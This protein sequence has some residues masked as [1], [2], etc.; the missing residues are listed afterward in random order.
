M[1]YR[2]QLYDQSPVDDEIETLAKYPLA[3]VDDVDDLLLF[4]RDSAK[5]QLD[6]GGAPVGAFE[7]TRPEVPVYLDQ[8]TDDPVDQVLEF[9]IQW[10]LGAC[11]HLI[12]LL[13]GFV[14]FVSFVLGNF[15]PPA[16]ERP[17][18]QASAVG[19]DVDLSV[20]VRAQHLRA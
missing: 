3:L 5:R 14:V 9:R 19:G 16:G 15:D 12:P 13:I 18:R 6:A 10:T 7:V 4:K 20:L 11:K 2:L 17:G 1:R 8:A